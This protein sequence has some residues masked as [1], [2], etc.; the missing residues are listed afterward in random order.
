[1][2]YFPHNLAGVVGGGVLQEQDPC[3]SAYDPSSWLTDLT[4]WVIV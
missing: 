4:D 1:M 3:L 2:S